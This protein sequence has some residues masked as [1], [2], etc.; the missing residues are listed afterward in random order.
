MTQSELRPIVFVTGMSGAGKSTTLNVLEDLG[1]EA[2]DNLPVSLLSRLVLS[3]VSNPVAIGIDVRARDFDS[4]KIMETVAHLRSFSSL[5]IT[6]LFLECDDSELENRF[7]T[8]RRRHPLARDRQVKDGIDQERKLLVALKEASDLVIDSTG[9]TV[10][11]F[12][13]IV[14]EHFGLGTKQGIVVFVSS[15]SYAKGLPRD[16]DLVFDVRFLKNP[17]YDEDLRPFS[18]QNQ[19][20]GDYI[21]SDPD[22]ESFLDNLKSLLDPLLSRYAEEGK[23]YLTVSFGCTG[24]RHRSVFVSKTIEEWIATKGWQT[25]ILHRDLENG[26][27]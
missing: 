21:S 11:A 26:E 23:R 5:S 6:T 1:Y 9:Q 2:V 16:A 20:V 14:E 27:K 17:H 10:V 22:F 13:Q 15:F 24:G 12:R 4:Q 3:D 25:R 7:R 18:G 8:T 19:A